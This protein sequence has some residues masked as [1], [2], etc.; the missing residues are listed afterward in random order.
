[1][2]LTGGFLCRGDLCLSIL[3]FFCVVLSLGF[4]VGLQVANDVC[5]CGGLMMFG[6]D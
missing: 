6:V 5:S 2:L 1:M 3:L 4:D